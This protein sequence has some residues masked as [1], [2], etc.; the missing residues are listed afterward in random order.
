LTLLAFS[1]FGF[2]LFGA[3][4]PLVLALLAVVAVLAWVALAPRRQ[5]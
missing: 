4:L 5:G 1:V 2:S 3:R